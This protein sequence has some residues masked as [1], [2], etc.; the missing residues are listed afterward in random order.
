MTMVWYASVLA[1]LLALAAIGPASSQDGLP[2]AASVIDGN[3][4]EV[5]GKRVRLYGIDAS[6]SSQLCVQPTG[7]R[8]CSL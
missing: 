2:G 3:T 1:L 7:E 8:W 5:R 4:I 6:E